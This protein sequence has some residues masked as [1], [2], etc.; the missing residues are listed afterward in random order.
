LCSSSTPHDAVAVA[1]DRQDRS[2]LKSLELDREATLI[3]LAQAD[4]DYKKVASSTSAHDA[5]STTSP[6]AYDTVQL[7]GEPG[8]FG[9]VSSARDEIHSIR[10][11]LSRTAVPDHEALPEKMIRHSRRISSMLEDDKERLSQRWSLTLQ[12]ESDFMSKELPLKPLELAPYDENPVQGIEFAPKSARSHSQDANALIERHHEG[13]EAPAFDPRVILQY[14]SFLSWINQLDAPSRQSTL[15]ALK[16]DIRQS[17]NKST[18]L[19][20]KSIITIIHHPCMYEGVCKYR[21]GRCC[22]CRVEWIS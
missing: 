11:S 21:F 6:P 19:S 4:S 15:R 14:T 10:S 12:K 17:Y 7:Y 9:L 13:E 1:Q 16:H 5:A 3:E 8:V 22:R 18:K 2:L 20:G